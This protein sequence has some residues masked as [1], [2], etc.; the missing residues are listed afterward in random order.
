MEVLERGGREQVG[1]L[2]AIPF[3]QITDLL[4]E[5]ALHLGNTLRQARPS[6]ASIELGLENSAW[7][8]ASWWPSS[9]VGRARRI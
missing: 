8:T 4:G 9:S 2:D 1:L 3:Q 5:V 7:K 6:K